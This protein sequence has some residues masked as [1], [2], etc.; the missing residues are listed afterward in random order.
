MQ[1]FKRRFVPKSVIVTTHGDFS[2]NLIAPFLSVDFEEIKP[3][4][5]EEH[6]DRN[7]FSGSSG[8]FCRNFCKRHAR[9]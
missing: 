8:G 2:C 7:A 9:T 1:S 3:W 6:E 5:K 4:R